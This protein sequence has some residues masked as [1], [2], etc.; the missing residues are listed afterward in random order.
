LIIHVFTEK[1]I[2]GRVVDTNN[3]PVSG[4]YITGCPARS[5]N[6]LNLS[7]DEIVEIVL[8]ARAVESDES[9]YFSLRPLSQFER[10]RLEVEAEGYINPERIISASNREF[11]RII[12][13]RP[14][15]L[16]G[17]VLN[18]AKQPIQGADVYYRYPAGSKM[19]FSPDSTTDENGYFAYEET[20]E[21]QITVF[22]S[23]SNYG[24]ISVQARV[25]EDKSNKVELILQGGIKVQL[26][27]KNSQ[28][29]PV[30]TAL[31]T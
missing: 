4:V 28:G 24:N 20:P 2:E 27:V 7:F 18:A 6:L 23:H 1:I 12:L 30:R 15:V 11:Q 29:S 22:A 10:I 31:E 8:F 25:F 13:K 26:V 17:R 5:D 19:D 14:C 16:E 3:K 21:G 9:G